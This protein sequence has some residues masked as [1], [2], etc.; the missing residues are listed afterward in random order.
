MLYLFTVCFS[1]LL[2]F[3]FLAVATPRS[4]ILSIALLSSYDLY[5]LDL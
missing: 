3:L 1:M 2:V 5:D 4:D